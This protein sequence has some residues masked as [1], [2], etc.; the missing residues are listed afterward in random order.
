MLRKGRHFFPFRM[1]PFLNVSLYAVLCILAH[2]SSFF[3]LCFSCFNR[4][5]KGL[6]VHSHRLLTFYYSFFF[7]RVS[8]GTFEAWCKFPSGQPQGP[9]FFHIKGAV[10]WPVCWECMLCSWWGVGIES[11]FLGS[12]AGYVLRCTGSDHRRATT[13]WAL[14]FLHCS[15]TLPPL[16]WPQQIH[17]WTC[18]KVE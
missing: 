17:A 12:A 7:L 15:F 1:L 3:L 9:L 18:V 5:H 2:S 4:C 13:P 8:S 11:P 16:P 10:C 14:F 6:I